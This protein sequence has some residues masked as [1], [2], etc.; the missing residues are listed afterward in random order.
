MRAYRVK[1]RAARILQKN[2]CPACSILL[3]PETERFHQGCPWYLQTHSPATVVIHAEVED[4][5]ED[6]IIGI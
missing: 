2:Q 1:V 5:R 4:W 3:V 6:F